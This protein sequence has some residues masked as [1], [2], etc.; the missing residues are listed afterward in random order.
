MAESG[1]QVSWIS[2]YLNGRFTPESGHSVYISPLQANQITTAKLKKE[3]QI[4]EHSDE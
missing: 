2:G 3:Q 1:P 4:T